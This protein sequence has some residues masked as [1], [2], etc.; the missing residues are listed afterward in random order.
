MS[1]KNELP[2]IIGHSTRTGMIIH[3]NIKFGGY[4][5][6]I[7]GLT[8]EPDKGSPFGWK[9]IDWVKAV[10]HFSDMEALE[11]TAETLSKAVKKWRKAEE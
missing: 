1:G 10:L 2:I 8:E 9:F 6:L 7:V 4:D 3:K 11:L 5:L